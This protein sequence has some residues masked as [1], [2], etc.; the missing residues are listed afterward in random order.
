MDHSTPFSSIQ[1]PNR[2]KNTD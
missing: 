1:Q 2:S